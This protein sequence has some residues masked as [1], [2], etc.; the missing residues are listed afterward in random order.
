MSPQDRQLLTEIN[1]RLKKVENYT[2]KIGGSLE[3]QNLVKRYAGGTSRASSK[4]ATTENQSVNEAGSATYS[5]LKTPDGF[6]EV[7]IGGATHYHP[8]YL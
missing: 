8:Y 4:G 7:T 6:D 5:V 1:E 3:F 2:T